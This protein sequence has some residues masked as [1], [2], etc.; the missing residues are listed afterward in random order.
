MAEIN[1]TQA[2]ADLLLALEKQRKD[3]DE[4]D[5][6]GLGGYLHIPL[7]STDKRENFFLDVER[8]S[9]NLS[10]GKYQNRA[11]QVV[12]L[13]RIDF[14]GAPHR[15][16]DD[17]EVPCPHLHLYREGYADKW[18]IPLP[19]EQFPSPTDPWQTLHDFMRYCNISLP[20]TIRRGLHA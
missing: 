16:P 4:W 15:N 11:R 18:A 5:Y 17:K 20:P 14:G 8:S 10:K 3:E 7:I 9:I 12:V 2:E 6:P 13:A 1:L 19:P